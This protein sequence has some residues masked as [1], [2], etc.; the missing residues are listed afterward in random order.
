MDKQLNIK[1]F[2][3]T[4]KYNTLI[5]NEYKITYSI[6]KIWYNIYLKLTNQF[7]PIITL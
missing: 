5:D 3:A 2:I 7:E 6:K 4:D 1:Y